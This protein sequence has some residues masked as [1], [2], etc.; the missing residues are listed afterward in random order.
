MRRK[1]AGQKSGCGKLQTALR[2]NHG[3]L[4]NWSNSGH[5]G[6]KMADWNP[7]RWPLKSALEIYS[8]AAMAPADVLTLAINFIRYHMMEVVLSEIRTTLTASHS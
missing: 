3:P 5:A 8:D 2:P 4:G 6:R 1:L 7:D